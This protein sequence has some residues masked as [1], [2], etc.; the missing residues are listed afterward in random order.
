MPDLIA[1]RVSMFLGSISTL[2]PQVQNGRLRAIAT[3]LMADAGPALVV[4]L[5]TT[6]TVAGVVV[7]LRRDGG[8][9]FTAEQLDMM[10]A[11]ADQ[12]ALAWQLAGTQRRMRELDL[13]ADRDR[14][15]RDLHD[16]VIQ[17]LFAA[18]L[19]LQSTIAR[20]DSPDV[21]DRLADTVDELQS[22]I[23]D[24]RTTIFDLHGRAGGSTRL[25][26]RITDVIAR[27][28]GIGPRTTAHFVGPLSVVGK[29][30]ADHAEAVVREAVS[31][32]VR[33]AGGTGVAVT[34]RVE[35]D[36]TI[37]VTDDGCGMPAD[38]TAS[39]LN[40]LRSRAE[41]MGGELVISAAPGGGTVLRWSAPLT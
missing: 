39:G 3:D 21:A 27:F 41:Q 40:N 24:I 16:H 14:I 37:E 9:E 22:V 34:V 4:P 1:G 2:N 6:E 17:R 5:R 12:A 18:G 33:H 29:S 11:F 26:Q 36:L 31:N 38:V 25:R 19:A 13:I 32:A 20:T 30:L 23:Q 15:A 10:A 28:S 7:V 35:D 8:P